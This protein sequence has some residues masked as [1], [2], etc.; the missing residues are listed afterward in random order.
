MTVEVAKMSLSGVRSSHLSYRPAE[1]IFRDSFMIGGGRG[2]V[3]ALGVLGSE[4]FRGFSAAFAGV[5]T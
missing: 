5:P 3:K 1:G 4:F 2:S